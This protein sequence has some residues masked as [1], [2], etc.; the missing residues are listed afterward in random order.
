[1]F[2]GHLQ[3]NRM[4]GTPAVLHSLCSHRTYSELR[5]GARK[6][7]YAGGGRKVPLRRIQTERS[8]ICQK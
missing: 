5:Y 6:Y 4:A 1:V 2:Q 7:L 8:C 3:W